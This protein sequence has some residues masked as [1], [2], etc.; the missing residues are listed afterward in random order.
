M[1]GGKYNEP[2]VENI[3]AKIEYWKNEI[4]KVVKKNPTIPLTTEHMDLDSTCKRIVDYARTDALHFFLKDP[5]IWGIGL[6]QKM[7]KGE[8]TKKF[9]LQFL[10]NKK[11]PKDQ[12]KDECMIP[13]SINNFLTDVLESQLKIESTSAH[14]I[15]SQQ[16][17][18]R[19]RDDF[20]AGSSIS[21][22]HGSGDDGTLTGVWKGLLSNEKRGLTNAHVALGFG[23]QDW[24]T[25][26]PGSILRL[27][28]SPNGR[29]IITA[30]GHNVGQGHYE[31]MEID[32][33]WPIL[34]PWPLPIPVIGILPVVYVDGAA[35][36][37]HPK[38]LPPNSSVS[39]AST[40]PSP[41]SIQ[42][43]KVITGGK[44]GHATLAL[45]GSTVLKFGARLQI[46]WGQVKISFLQIAIP[47]PFLPLVVIFD[48][49]LSSLEITPGDS[50]SPLLTDS[51]S[52]QFLG[53]CWGGLP[54]G[55]RM[56]H[57]SDII[58]RNT[59]STPWYWYA[60]L[61]NLNFF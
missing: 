15:L 5:N 52:L 12:V 45:P 50:G 2:D 41:L 27:F 36:K 37:I 25:A 16:L 57:S 42:E 14:N 17:S 22:V 1:V 24:V 47:I 3:L 51:P 49:I 33:P 55:R 35:G 39:R 58:L 32:T 40:I 30:S 7:V 18:R 53:S 54:P 23:F 13:P 60:L 10:V 61:M 20:E 34:V 48:Q 38:I 9:V 8:N 4:T 31:L 26:L 21:E 56:Q 44:M 59:L 6:G 19:T 28:E 11:L 43:K 46:R 29:K